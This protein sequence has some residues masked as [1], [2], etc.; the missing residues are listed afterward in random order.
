MLIVLPHLLLQNKGL[1][2]IKGS[3]YDKIS[4]IS[5]WEN[6][7]LIKISISENKHVSYNWALTIILSLL[8]YWL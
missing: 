7:Q 6:L 3:F 5:K 2:L 4:Y 8:S 1:L